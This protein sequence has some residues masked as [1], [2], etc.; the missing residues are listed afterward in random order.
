MKN[1]EALNKKSGGNIIFKGKDIRGRKIEV[2]PTGLLNLDE[3]LSCGGMPRGRI[4]TISGLQST[5]K[6]SLCLSLI[7]KYQKEGV[8]CCF[9]DAEYSLSLPYAEG[10]GVDTDELLIVEP[11]TGEQAFEA[12]ESVLRDNLADF[13]VVDSTSALVSKAEMEAETGKPTMGGQARLISQGLRKIIGLLSKKKA[14]LVFIN[15]LRMNIMGGQYDPYV[16]AGGIALKFYTS[17]ALR[18]S[19]D[20]ALMDGEKLV[21]YGIKVKVI[22]NKCGLPGGEA[23]IQLIFKSGFSEEASILDI[24]LTRNIIMRKGNS[25][26]YK[27]QLLGKS[28]KI[29]QEFL[30]SDDPTINK[31][32]AEI[33][34]Q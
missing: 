4:V 17:I 20:K 11:E 2:L 6:T 30:S 7:A 16:E 15:Q 28:R 21:G 1:I 24:G 22:K 9:V 23:I 10:L 32:V 13:I 12:I 29:A 14:T 19:R 25:Y 3:A 5:S 27:E 8:R 31:I 34:S 33:Q 26:F 18:L